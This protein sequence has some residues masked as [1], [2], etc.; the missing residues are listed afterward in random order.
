MHNEEWKKF[1][2]WHPDYAGTAIQHYFGDIGDEET[3]AMDG[4]GSAIEVPY[5]QTWHFATVSEDGYKI[6]SLKGLWNAVKDIVTSRTQLI[7]DSR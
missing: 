3:M 6:R 1:A 2:T 7:R 5:D 4:P